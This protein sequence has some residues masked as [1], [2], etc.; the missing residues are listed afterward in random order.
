MM[1]R[2]FGYHAEGRLQREAWVHPVH[3]GRLQEDERDAPCLSLSADSTHLD[4]SRILPDWELRGSWLIAEA[5]WREDYYQRWSTRLQCAHKH[6]EL[7]PAQG[8]ILPSPSA[9][10][11]ACWGKCCCCSRQII[12]PSL[13][14][15]CT[16]P[17]KHTH[18]A[19]QHSRCR[20]SKARP[21]DQLF[22][23]KGKTSC[24]SLKKVTLHLPQL[25]LESHQMPAHH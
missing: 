16:L 9:H 5:S 8:W 23:A 15:P 7:I 13:A 21:T 4:P 24:L 1:F 3:P 18:S 10:A 22:L 25:C 6:R 2:A 12:A 17:C 19:F 14:S 20:V 11:P